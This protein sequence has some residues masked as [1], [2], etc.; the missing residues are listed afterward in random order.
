MGEVIKTVREAL[1][2][3]KEIAKEFAGYSLAVRAIQPAQ[4]L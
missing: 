3:R 2:R 4:K 1:R